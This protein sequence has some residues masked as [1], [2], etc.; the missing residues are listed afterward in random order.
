MKWF[1]CTCAIATALAA[2]TPAVAAAQQVRGERRAPGAPVRDVRRAVIRTVDVQGGDRRMTATVPPQRETKTLQIGATGSLDVKTIAGDITVTAGSGR[3]ATVEIVRE[4]RGVTEADARAGLERVKVDVVE[5]GETATIETV[6]PEER[7][8]PYSVKVSYVVVAPAGTRVTARTVSGAVRMKGLKADQHAAVTSG[9]IDVSGVTG[10]IRTNMI[11]GPTTITGVTTDA[12]IEVQSINGTVTL[13][14]VKARR[15]GVNVT[16]GGVTL[17]GVATDDL[18]VATIDGDIEFDSP[19][20]RSGRYE[21]QAMSGSLTF[22]VSGAAGIELKANTFSGDVR[23]EP[24]LDFKAASTSRRS[25]RGTIGDA[26]ASVALHTFSGTI[27][28]R[29]K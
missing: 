12:A 2:L 15:V 8:P 7:N 25:L 5:R 23:V 21:L 24:P 4:A 20:G 27:V 16:S 26:A 9:S 11:S 17:R 22:L 3:A 6:Y 18:G 10:A 19:L 1:R 28:I 13:D 29:K 14:Q